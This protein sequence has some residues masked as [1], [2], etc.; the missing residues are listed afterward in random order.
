MDE[1]VVA[2]ETGSDLLACHQCFRTAGQQAQQ[3]HWLALQPD[4]S[5]I[6]Q[7]SGRGE[8]QLKARTEAVHGGGELYR[9]AGH[10]RSKLLLPQEFA[11]ARKKHP[12]STSA[13]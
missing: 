8:V 10:R 2:P 11:R 6:P 13:P 5:T 9:A 12:L 1:H 4:G 3:V 7:K